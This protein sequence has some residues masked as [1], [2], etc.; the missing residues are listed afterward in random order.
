MQSAV[1]TIY[2]YIYASKDQRDEEGMIEGGLS[3]K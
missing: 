1:G 2:I 3:T